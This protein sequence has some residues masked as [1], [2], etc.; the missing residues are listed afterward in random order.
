[1]ERVL[2][3][4]AY[5]RNRNILNE[6]EQRRRTVLP[7][8]II[9]NESTT[10]KLID[11]SVPINKETPVYPGDPV[12]KIEPA[13]VL[14]EDG[15][16]DHYVC[17][18][19]HVGTHVDAPRHMLEGAK[20]LEQIPVEKFSGRGVYIKTDKNFDLEVV[21]QASIQEGD[22]VLLHTGMS[23]VYHEVDYYENYSAL[24]EEIA[25]YLVEK[26]VKMVG[27]D[28]CSVD[29]EPFPIHQILL[30]NDVLIIENLTNLGALEGK[31]FKIYA[32]PI[33][34]EIDGAPAR[35]VAEVI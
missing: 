25:N 26:K 7:Q 6:R 23:D 27:V 34:L 32:F 2:P 16:E 22:I 33:K 29:H 21:K 13:G 8:E 17:M 12:T 10:M 18:G 19:T 35:V 31:N 11:L 24:T 4:T 30:G 5:A 1:M 20:G 3:K 28:M 14:K 15:Y 9:Y